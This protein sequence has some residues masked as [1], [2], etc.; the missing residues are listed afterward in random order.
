VDIYGSDM[1]STQKFLPVIIVLAATMSLFAAGA[2]VSSV[3]AQ[4]MT[5][6]N[7]TGGNMT[8]G[9][10]TGGNMTGGNMTGGNMTGAAK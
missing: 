4:N 8:G 5:G 10:M 6:G 9:N 7:M 2:I 1:M 3:S